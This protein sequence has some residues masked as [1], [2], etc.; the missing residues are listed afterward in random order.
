M[1]T[2]AR[3]S[4]ILLAAAISAAWPA[5]AQTDT[6]PP[7]TNA[8]VAPRPRAAGFR[9]TIA[10]VDTT[11]MVLTLKGRG[12]NPGAKVKVT[13]TTKI[14]KDGEPGQFSDA[15]E[16]MRVQ[17]SGKKDDD[18]VW[19]A[20]TLNITKPPPPKPPAAAPPAPGQ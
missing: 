7:S 18:G 10:S 4:A 2:I 13:S 14:K 19:V 1:K 8:P 6:T 11:N 12:A 20:N 17:G 3:L 9:G 15:V 5:Q 16:G